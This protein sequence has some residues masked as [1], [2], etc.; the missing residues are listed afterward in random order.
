M[1]PFFRADQIDTP[2]LMYHGGDDNNTGT[3]P[4]QSRRMIHALTTLGKDGSALRV[5]V[6]VTHAARDGS[7][8]SRRNNDRSRNPETLGIPEA[9]DN[10]SEDGASGRGARIGFGSDGDGVSR[11]SDEVLSG[12]GG[13][14]EVPAPLTEAQLD[15][16]TTKPQLSSRLTQVSKARRLLRGS[17]DPED[18]ALDKELQAEFNEIMKRMRALDKESQAS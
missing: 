8:G 3:F 5:P 7:N 1:S 14:V 12:S 6:R 4:V 13:G 18:Q 2:L 9:S 15:A 10:G 16:L 11:T 17:E